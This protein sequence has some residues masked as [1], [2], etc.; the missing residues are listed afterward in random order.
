MAVFISKKFLFEPLYKDDFTRYKYIWKQKKKLSLTQ[1]I[2]EVHFYTAA[3][4]VLLS[5]FQNIGWIDL[6]NC[7]HFFFL[8][9]S[10]PCCKNCASSRIPQGNFVNMGATRA[11]VALW[12]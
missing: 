6:E 1:N 12:I 4:K 2:V 11:G 8:P 7:G 10:K 3:I 9:T 5:S